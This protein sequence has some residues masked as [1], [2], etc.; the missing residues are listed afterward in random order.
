M[1]EEAKI[2][3]VKKAAVKELD[4]E[5]DKCTDALSALEEE[6]KK[7]VAAQMTVKTEKAQ[8]SHLY[9]LYQVPK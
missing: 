4:Q 7:I 6:F 2:E 3:K 1:E 9:Q 5:K 8:V